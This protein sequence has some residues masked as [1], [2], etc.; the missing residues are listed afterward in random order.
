MDSL[1]HDERVTHQFVSFRNRRS[2]V[3]TIILEP[4]TAK[5]FSEVSGQTEV[6]D[7]TGGLCGLFFPT[8]PRPYVPEFTKEE[9]DRAEAEPGGRPLAEILKDLQARS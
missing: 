7:E 4:K 2:A 3:N 1:R 5:Q 8:P 6:R 9:L